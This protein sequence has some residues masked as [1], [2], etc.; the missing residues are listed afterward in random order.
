MFLHPRK[1]FKNLS[2]TGFLVHNIFWESRFEQLN[3]LQL[4]V[5]QNKKLESIFE[6]SWVFA[7]LYTHVQ[8]Y[9]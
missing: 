2:P 1:H 8:E 5:K 3:F 6:L 7:Y 4:S 9:L